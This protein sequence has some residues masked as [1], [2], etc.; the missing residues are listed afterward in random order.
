MVMETASM[1]APTV[2]NVGPGSV[3]N[4]TDPGFTPS[5]LATNRQV[6]TED[7]D[8]TNFDMVKTTSNMMRAVMRHNDA[9]NAVR[10]KSPRFLN[11]YIPARNAIV[12]KTVIAENMAEPPLD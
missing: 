10:F 2:F 3:N 4:E 11:R 6:I 5:Y 9:E 12:G 1:P 7:V 8:G